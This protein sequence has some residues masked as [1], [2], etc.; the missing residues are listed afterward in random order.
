M[1]TWLKMHSATLQGVR[2]HSRHPALQPASVM[3]LYG[4]AKKIHPTQKPHRKQLFLMLYLQGPYPR[5]LPSQNPQ[6]G[7]SRGMSCLND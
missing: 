4:L 5:A 3:S 2:G 6:E 7:S 1:T